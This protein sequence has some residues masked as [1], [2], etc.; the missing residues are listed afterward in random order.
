MSPDA[1]RVAR[2]QF[3]NALQPFEGPIGAIDCTDIA[4]LAPRKHEEAYI[5]HHEY[6]SLNV[7]MVL[8]LSILCNEMNKNNSDILLYEYL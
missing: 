2:E 6:H 1:S 3:R 5:N 4:I 7:E 8:F